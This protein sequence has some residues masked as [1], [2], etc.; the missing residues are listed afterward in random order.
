MET[1]PALHDRQLLQLATRGYYHR[2]CT[3]RIACV[4]AIGIAIGVVV[5][6]LVLLALYCI[7]CPSYFRDFYRSHSTP[8]PPEQQMTAQQLPA[9]QYWS[10]PQPNAAQYLPPDPDW[11]AQQAG[12]GAGSGTVAGWPAAYTVSDPYKM[13]G[14]YAAQP[15]YAPPQYGHAAPGDACGSQAR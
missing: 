4:G 5:L 2:P 10:Q 3:E 14:G 15:Q 1:A 6:F 11:Q 8:K 7:C 13:P 9:Q 12:Q